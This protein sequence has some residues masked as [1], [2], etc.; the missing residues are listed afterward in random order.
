MLNNSKLAPNLEN[1]LSDVNRQQALL[2]KSLAKVTP[3]M[4]RKALAT[5]TKT[6][7]TDAPEIKS[8]FDSMLSSQQLSV[9]LR[10]YDP[11]TD[12]ATPVIIF[13]HGGGHMCGSVDVYD[14]VCR[15]LAV[16]CQHIVVSVEYSLAPEFP[17]PIALNEC[18]AVVRGIWRHL[19][20]YGA[21]YQRNLSLVGD[22]GGGA[23]C[24]TLCANSQSDPSLAIQRQA[25]IY[26]S[27][28]YTLSSPSVE[29]LSKG[30]LLEKGRI[31]WY[32]DHYLQ[33]GEN[34]EEVSPLSLPVSASLPHT[35]VITAGFCPLSDEGKRY[36]ARLSEAGAV[37]EHHEE[38]SQIHAYLN[39]EN[40]VPEA[41]ERTYKYIAEFINSEEKTL[42]A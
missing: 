25:L 21:R 38:P 42:C 1:W 35:L 30:Y 2:D 6:H 7:V 23:L 12:I 8:V 16:A 36:V 28:D 41:C 11:A 39:L 19:D 9:P 40:L 27:L 32:F 29:A 15:K 4:M 3:K 20:G 10:I 34:R 26:P 33:N 13:I 5:M 24:A 17:Y 22:S 18:A 37:A 14:A 31:E